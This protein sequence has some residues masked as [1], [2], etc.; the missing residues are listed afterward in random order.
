M[1]GSKK[2]NNGSTLL[3]H[4]RIVDFIS[5]L[6]GTRVNFDNLGNAPG[7]YEILNYQQASWNMEFLPSE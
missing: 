1:P 5:P 3:Q 2:M 4:L 6:T 7:R